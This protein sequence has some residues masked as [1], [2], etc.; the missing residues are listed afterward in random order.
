MY[1]FD[2][3]NFLYIDGHAKFSSG[4]QYPFSHKSA[5]AGAITG[6]VWV[7]AKASQGGDWPDRQ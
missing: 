2:G 4:G 3:K 6:D 1:H 5:R 7:A